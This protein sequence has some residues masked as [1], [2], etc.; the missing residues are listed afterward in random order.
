MTTTWTKS[1]FIHSGDY[2]S[3]KGRFVARFKHKKGPTGKADFLK[4]LQKRFTP[5]A[6]F[7][8]LDSGL[9]P[10]QVLMGNDP[11]WYEGKVAAWKA[12]HGAR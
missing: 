2:T 6:Y 9:A 10:L 11:A 7:A 3:Y 4:Q 8:A 5:E 1:D 12:K